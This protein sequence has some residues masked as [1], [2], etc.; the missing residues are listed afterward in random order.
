M[1]LA[2]TTFLTDAYLTARFFWEESA[3]FR[4]VQGPDHCSLVD[5]SV[6][7][8]NARSH[9]LTSPLALKVP[10]ISQTSKRHAH[11]LIERLFHL[12]NGRLILQLESPTFEWWAFLFGLCQRTP[13]TTSGGMLVLQV[14]RP[15]CTQTEMMHVV[16]P[17]AV[18]MSRGFDILCFL[19]D[20]EASRRC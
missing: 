11:T 8:L 2:T 18:T 4:L 6:P 1:A 15:Q 17:S 13:P 3:A 14:S 16:K 10:R 9:G 12:S 19:N 20:V 5:A 7:T